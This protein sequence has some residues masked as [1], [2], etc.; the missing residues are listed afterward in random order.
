MEV[1]PFATEWQAIRNAKTD[2][3]FTGAA[4]PHRTTMFCVIAYRFG[5]AVPEVAFSGEFIALLH[6][7]PS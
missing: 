1:A 4:Q 3:L 6:F 7:P 5:C 2:G